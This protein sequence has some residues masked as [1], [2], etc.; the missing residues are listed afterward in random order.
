MLDKTYLRHYVIEPRL[1]RGSRSSTRSRLQ[2]PRFQAR[3]DFHASMKSYACPEPRPLVCSVGAS[4]N[5]VV[6]LISDD[7][8]TVQNDCQTVMLM[9]KHGRKRLENG[10]CAD[11]LRFG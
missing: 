8:V 6:I 1:P 9:A 11:L 5:N 3:F 7:S 10:A 4:I 2:L